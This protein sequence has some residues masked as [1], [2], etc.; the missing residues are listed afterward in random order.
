MSYFSHVEYLSLGFTV[1]STTLYKIQSQ[2]YCSR[3]VYSVTIATD[4]PKGTSWIHERV[5]PTGGNKNKK[6]QG[7]YG[8]NLVN[9]FCT[10]FPNCSYFM[11]GKKKLDF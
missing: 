2:A 8:L 5:L 9:S 1:I 11:R 7:K 10:S 6:Y 3:F 4:T